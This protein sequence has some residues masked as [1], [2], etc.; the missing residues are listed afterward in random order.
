MSFHDIT[1]SAVGRKMEARD[2]VELAA[3]GTTARAPTRLADIRS[4]LD[5]L[6]GHLWVPV[7]EVVLGCVE[8]LVQRGFLKAPGDQPGFTLT[9]GGRRH[10]DK[11]LSQPTDCPICPQGQVALKLKLAFIDLAP[12]A[13]RRRHLEQIVCVYERE[14]AGW[15]RRCRDCPRQGA[16][17]RMWLDI[18]TDR[19]QREIT[20]LR[21]MASD[22]VAAGLQS[23][24][25]V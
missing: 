25:H 5:D 3:L 7:F 22:P 15:S 9:E 13:E 18:E 10:L 2:F 24:H 17:G 6:V 12:L 23:R 19:L 1:G 8:N 4:T 16:L 20:M 21:H 14:V 11:L